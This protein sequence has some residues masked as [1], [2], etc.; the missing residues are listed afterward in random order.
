MFSILS[1]RVTAEGLSNILDV[2]SGSLFC[3]LHL[4]ISEILLY[5][6][7][8]MSETNNYGFPSGASGKE[9][10]CQWRKFERCEF[11]P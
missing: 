1:K 6:P 7:S 11:G 2:I 10:T 3:L 8:K 9:P 4:T 5:S